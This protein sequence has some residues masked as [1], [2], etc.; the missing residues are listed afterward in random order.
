MKWKDFLNPRSMLT[1]GIAGSVVMVIANTL[2]VEFMLPQKWTALILSFL[3]IIPILLSFSAS[4]L[5][6]VIYFIFNG[7]II[8]SLAANTNFAGAKLQELGAPDKK[9][10]ASQLLSTPNKTLPDS[11]ISFSDNETQVKKINGMQLASNDKQEVLTIS[12]NQPTHENPTVN[13]KEKGKEN[14]GK[15]TQK[16]EKNGRENREFFGK[17]F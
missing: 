8:F 1:P 16:Q 11:A 7:L 17:W 13:S 6:N 15:N 2:W 12:K 10:V 4:K 9:H 3:L 14:T 5:E